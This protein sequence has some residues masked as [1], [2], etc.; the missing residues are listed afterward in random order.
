M[1]FFLLYLGKKSGEVAVFF[2]KM[3]I[4]NNEV[5]CVNHLG[6]FSYL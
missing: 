2:C 5:T 1:H 6:W 4:Q 3:E